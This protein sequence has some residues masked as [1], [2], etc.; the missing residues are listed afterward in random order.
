MSKR[1][2]SSASPPGPLSTHVERGRTL[3]L[4]FA[5][6]V[7]ACRPTPSSDASFSPAEPRAVVQEFYDWYLSE[8]HSWRNI[9]TVLAERPQ[10]LTDELRGLLLADRKCVAETQG[11]C[12]LSF[13]PFINAQD[14][15]GRYEAAGPVPE[16]GT[17]AV[18]VFPTCEGRRDSLPRV[19]VLLARDSTGWRFAD[20]WYDLEGTTLLG[21]LND[22]TGV[23]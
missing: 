12:T 14:H 5:I 13:D 15:C 1:L 20:F 10:L 23:R 16:H 4:G 7:T 9:D 18:P 17:L 2:G 8:S 21:M 11:I 22:S 6:L 19:I 3:L